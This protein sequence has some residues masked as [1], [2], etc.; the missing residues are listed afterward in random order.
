MVTHDAAC[1][2]YVGRWSPARRRAS[3][4][5][6]NKYPFRAGLLRESGGMVDALALEASGATRESSSLSFRTSDSNAM[7]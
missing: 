4:F 3:I 1:Q 5:R 7:E 6:Y 2:A